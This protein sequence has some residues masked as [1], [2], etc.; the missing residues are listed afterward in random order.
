MLGAWGAH[1]RALA[2]G[3]AARLFDVA[4]RYHVWHGLALFGV[5]LLCPAEGHPAP[6]LVHG[7][8]VA[9]V[10][11]IVLFS[12]GLYA[13]ALALSRDASPLVLTGGLTFMLGWMA[14]AVEALKAL[15]RRGA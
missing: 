7:A 5:A 10:L 14:L 11:G 2:D 1:G 9:F 12:G 15:V 4:H 13:E 8:G 3:N 6:V